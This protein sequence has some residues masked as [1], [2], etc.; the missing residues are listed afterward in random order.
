MHQRASGASVAVGLV[1]DGPPLSTE[2]VG[3]APSILEAAPVPLKSFEAI[4]A[5]RQ[6]TEQAQP[7]ETVETVETAEPVEV[8]DAPAAAEQRRLVVRLL[9][10]EELDLGTYDVRA[11]A[12]SAAQD[13]VA[14]F[15]SAEASGEWPEVDGRFLRPASVA[16]I[17]VLLQD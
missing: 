5:E 12:V 8:E 9:G 2:T 15:T 10:G 7:A 4:L 17:D 1:G 14:K 6:A 11:D 3:R 13:L 16:S